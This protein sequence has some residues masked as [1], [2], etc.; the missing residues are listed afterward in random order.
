MLRLA[1]PRCDN[2]GVSMEGVD[3]QKLAEGLTA[4]NS[5]VNKMAALLPNEAFQK[6]ATAASL[7]PAPATNEAPV[8]RP[9]SKVLLCEGSIIGR[10]ISVLLTP[11]GVRYE[12]GWWAGPHH[13]EKWFN[14][15]EVTQPADLGQKR[16]IG[17]V[18]PQG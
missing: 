7:E 9:G 13:E 1:M 3:L 17:F 8:F 4:L 12:V 6:P 15:V 14:A 2:K 18:E 11:Y 10:V 5:V 16:H